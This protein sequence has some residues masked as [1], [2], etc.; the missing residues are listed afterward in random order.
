V[1]EFARFEAFLN[2]AMGLDTKSVGAAM[3]ERAVR[4]RCATCGAA[5]I[6]AYWRQV[7][8]SPAELQ[9]LIELVIV[10]E[11]WFFR[12]GEAFKAIARLALTHSLRSVRPLRLL[13]LPCSTGEEPYSMAMALLDAGVPPA[14]FH[15]DAVDI[16]TRSIATAERAV[17]GRNSF[18]G[19]DLEFRNRHFVPVG[20]R[21]TLAGTVRSQVRFRHGNL[22]DPALLAEE[23]GYDFVFCRN[24]LIYF[25]EAEQARAV[26]V[27]GRL[28][29]DTGVLFVGPSEC[30]VLVRENMVSANMPLAFAFRKAAL[31]TPSQP[32]VAM[33]MRTA[34]SE[35][36]GSWM[37]RPAAAPA[38]RVREQARSKATSAPRLWDATPASSAASQTGSDNDAV[39]VAAR[40]ADQGRLLEAAEICNRLIQQNK[41]SAAAFYLLG[42]V[43]DAAG[44]HLE[45]RDHYRKTLYMEPDHTEALVHLAALLEMQGD[46]AGAR[47]M[48]DRA[49]RTIPKQQDSH[50]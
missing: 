49:R 32:K 35:T 16:C 13:S 18:R 33:P 31:P 19:K 5:D 24:V 9:E 45:A 29:N 4:E 1:N 21:H 39:A 48:S 26:S 3:I 22:F 37:T 10:P 23:C 25:G 17:Y 34:A 28:L 7:K 15:I 41:P 2:H 30:G 43:S 50:G 27:L 36:I 20:E 8:E 14:R 46:T 44:R 12:D 6:D 42:L 38:H 40:L 47:R 11:T